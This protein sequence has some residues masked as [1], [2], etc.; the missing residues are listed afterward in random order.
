MKVLFDCTALSHWVGHA[1]GIQRVVSEI[2][3]ELTRIIPNSAL[4]FFNEQGDSFYYSIDDR[5]VGDELTLNEGDLVITAGH[6][7]DYPTHHE[8]LLNLKNDGVLLGTLFYD[9]IPILFP[10]TY[11]PGFSFQF[12]KCLKDS[13]EISTIGFAIS[14]N[15][16]RDLECFANKADIKCP[17]IYTVRLGDDV[18]LS[19]SP[20]S[21]EIIDK[22]SHPF[23]LSVGTIEYRKN[24]IVLLNS[25]RYMLENSDFDPPKLLLVGR[26]GWLDHDLE[27]QVAN[28][29]RLHDRVEILTTISD[30]DLRHLYEKALFTVYPSY[31]EGWGLPVAESLCFG[32]PCIAS[33]SSSMLEI[34]PGLVRHANPYLVDEWAHQIRS[35]AESPELLKS[36]SEKIEREYRRYCW[37]ETAQQ[38][39][40]SLLLN[41]PHLRDT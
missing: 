14:E 28:D 41:F 7:W 19:V 38:I 21:S 5:V 32:K 34:A 15:T 4:I 31:Y 12:E 36:E 25:Y 40:R 11:G 9:T 13:L 16:K 18:P 33:G 23:I 3:S 20:P 6:N 22:A 30:A 37:A 26:K 35:L 10:F 8:H 1:T 39:K 2:G 27:Y 17:S 24:H 29:L